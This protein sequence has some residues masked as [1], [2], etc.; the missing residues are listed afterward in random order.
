LSF[1]GTSFAAGLAGRVLLVA[2]GSTDV[3]SAGSGSAYNAGIGGGAW[4]GGLIADGAGVHATAL[5]AAC[6]TAAA[7]LLMLGEPWLCGRRT[8][9]PG[10]PALSPAG[11]QR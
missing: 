10:A 4:I 8:P 7:L 9:A 1:A 5:A 6:L 2:P 3:A 11:V